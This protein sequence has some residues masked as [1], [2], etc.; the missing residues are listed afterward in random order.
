MKRPSIF[1]IILLIMALMV[2]FVIC[3][4]ILA[5]IINKVATTEANVQLR[6]K[7]ID[8]IYFVA[9]SVM[10][11]ISQKIVGGKNETAS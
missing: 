11:I 3:S 4:S 10:T 8:L 7:L 5:M 2:A 1:E 9:G 6:A